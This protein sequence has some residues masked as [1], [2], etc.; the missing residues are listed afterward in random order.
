L[1]CSPKRE[2]S[3]SV[4]NDV[5]LE[6]LDPPHGGTFRVGVGVVIVR[7]NLAKPSDLS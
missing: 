4:S 1:D 3:G 5:F 2:R 6:I 7:G